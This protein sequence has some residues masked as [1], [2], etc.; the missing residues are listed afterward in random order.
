MT[1]T[2]IELYARNSY[3]AVNDTFW[4]QDEIFGYIYGASLIMAKDAKCI[5]RTYTTTTGVG[6]QE[7]DFPTNVMGIKRITYGGMKL[8]QI[9]MREDDQLTSYNQTITDQGTSAFYWIWNETISLRPIP[10]AATTLKLWTYNYPGVV[11]VN[12]TLEIPERYHVELTNFVLMKMAAKDQNYE[13][14][15]YYEKKF[16]E[17]VKKVIRNMKDEKRGDSPAQ[18]QVDYR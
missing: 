8:T 14:A 15:Q 11:S 18:V 1:P 4:T 5:E 6:T 2:A 16:D 3:N 10:G 17:D 12:S 7:Y 13:A 9:T